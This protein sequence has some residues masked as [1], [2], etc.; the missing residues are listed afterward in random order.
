MTHKGG[1]VLPL[2]EHVDHV[3]LGTGSREHSLV[4][5][6][7]RL[8]QQGAAIEHRDIGF[9]HKHAGSQAV[10]HHVGYTLGLEGV[11]SVVEV[12]VVGPERG[13][14]APH[15]VVGIGNIAH[16]LVDVGLGFGHG[17]RRDASHAY[18]QQVARYVVAR[19]VVEQ[20]EEVVAHIGVVLVVAAIGLKG[21]EPVGLVG[22]ETA[23][24][25]GAAAQEQHV[26]ELVLVAVI[27]HLVHEPQCHGIGRA[28]RE[29]IEHLLL[30]E[31]EHLHAVFVV[32]HLCYALCLVEEV[33]VAHDDHVGGGLAVYV[34]VLDG[35]PAC[36]LHECVEW[37]END[38]LCPVFVNTGSKAIC[39][40]IVALV[41]GDSVGRAV[42][43]HWRGG[44]VDIPHH[45]VTAIIA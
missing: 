3:P 5:R 36:D 22:R 32:V 44:V 14:V 34:L 21:D 40:Y 7:R 45:Q 43:A 8:G 42:V 24:V 41:V 10:G 16:E 30:V 31:H 26:A 37:V 33:L 18:A 27:E 25:E 38:I 9:V 19:V 12:G 15:P 23:V 13:V 6:G 11:Q 17:G 39:F 4:E 35:G 20:A 29:L 1:K 28:A 2:L